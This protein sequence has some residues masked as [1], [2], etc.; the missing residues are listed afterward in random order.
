VRRSLF[1]VCLALVLRPLPGSAQKTPASAAASTI[2]KTSGPAMLAVAQAIVADTWNPLLDRRVQESPAAGRLGAAWKPSD[3]RWQKARESLARRMAQVMDRYAQSQEIAGHVAAEV[4]RVG[5]GP[6]LDA[7]VAALNGPLG[8]AL[9]HEEAKKE[10]VV[11]M[12]SAKPD[13]PKIASPEW[14]RQ[15]GELSKQFEARVGPKLAPADTAH[16]E[17]AQKLLSG[18]TGGTLTRI[19]MFVVSNAKRQMTTGLN[20]MVFDDQ[21]AIERDIAAAIGAAPAAA[22]G[23]PGK[24]AF[25]LEKMAV[26]QDSWLDWGA[27]DSRVGAFRDGFRAQFKEGGNGEYFVP[28]ASAS[29]MAMKVLRVYASTIG[30]ARGFSVLVDAPFDTVRKNVEKTIG[31]PLGKCESGEGMRNCELPIAEKRTIM[32]M[33]DATGKEKST[34]VGCFYFY[35]K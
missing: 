18:S 2:A 34:L 16:T 10:F 35:E 22:A 25:S 7:I 13:G 1:L 17:E 14:T 29:L 24:D 30:M 6:D 27:D 32:L 4:G 15:L 11:D 3:P 5:A 31:K 28:K 26:C 23:A 9:V 33:G 19:W 21:D 12:M 20:L 8:P